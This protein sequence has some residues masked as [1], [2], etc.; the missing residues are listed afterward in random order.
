M[1][2]FP[3]LTL[4][5]VFT[6]ALCWPVF[7]HA[8]DDSVASVVQK[9]VQK[10]PVQNVPQLQ[11]E[12]PKPTQHIQKTPVQKSQCCAV[13]CCQPLRYKFRSRT[14]IRER[15]RF[16]A[17]VNERERSHVRVRAPGV[18]VTVGGGCCR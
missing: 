10:T 12:M 16:F 2:K 14:V 18:R 5:A 8:G 11:V 7:S 9:T 13:P 17:R 15:G 3:V 1:K 6:I 4:V